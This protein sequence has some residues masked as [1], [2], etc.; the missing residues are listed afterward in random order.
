MSVSCK[1]SKALSLV[2]QLGAY[3]TTNDVNESSSLNLTAEI[4]TSDCCN[5]LWCWYTV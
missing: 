3:L 2:Y 1:I 4:V 5:Y